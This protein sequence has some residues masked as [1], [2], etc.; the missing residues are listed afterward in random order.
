MDSTIPEQGPLMG[1]QSPRWSP[2]V[3]PQRKV[4][5]HRMAVPGRE[6]RRERPGYK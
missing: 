3:P 1:A 6:E 5:K 2:V 4:R